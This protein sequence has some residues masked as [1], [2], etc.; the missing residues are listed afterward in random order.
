MSEQT[1]E[2]DQSVDPAMWVDRC[3]DYLYRYAFSR[4]RDAESAEEVVQET[5]AAALAALGQY[6][7][8]GA[9]RAWLLGILKRKIVDLIRQRNRTVSLEGERADDISESLFDQRGKWR[10][11]PRGFGS[12][13]SAAM[14]NQEFW[15]VF[16]RCLAGLPRRQADI[17]T[18]RELDGMKSE[19]ICKELGISS[20][21]LWVL[22]YRARLYL[23]NCM[24]SRGQAEGSP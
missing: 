18:L 12:V 24:K 6:A 7:G 20:S 11:D 4:L 9:E 3:G 5:F 1:H 16:R 17:F 15:N 14:E 13:P 22:L 10:V 19:Q 8:R 21:N 2:S 23:S